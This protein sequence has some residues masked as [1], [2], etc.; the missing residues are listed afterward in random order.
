[1]NKSGNLWAVVYDEPAAAERARAV[2]RALQDFHCLMVDDVAIVT[3]RPDGSFELDREPNPGLAVTGGCGLFGFLAGLV[4]AQPL[5]GAALGALLG[6]ALAAAG[7]GVGIGDAFI[8]EVEAMMAPGATVLFVMDEWSDRE[9]VLYHLRNLG[10]KVLKTNVDPAW[11][12]EI[13]ATLL[14]P[15]PATAN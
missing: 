11:A 7:A 2:V 6:A 15:R 5:A 1:V 12:E 10:G 9:A 3:R 14:N 8:R 4:V 13:Q